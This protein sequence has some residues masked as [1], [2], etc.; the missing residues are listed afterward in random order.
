MVTLIL[1]QQETQLLLNLLS[2][3][4]DEGPAGAGWKSIEAVSL[5]KKI[6]G[7]SNLTT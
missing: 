3:V 1:T 5:I 6:E 2:E 7:Q 4:Q